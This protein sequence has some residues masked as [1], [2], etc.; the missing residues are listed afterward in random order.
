[1]EWFGFSEQ[2]DWTVFHE[3]EVLLAIDESADS[4]DTS[5]F[6]GTVIVP[7]AGPCS[8]RADF[9]IGIDDGGGRIRAAIRWWVTLHV[10]TAGGPAWQTAYGIRVGPGRRPP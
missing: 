7:A 9:R 4:G 10:T 5:L 1:M 3:E 8:D 2:Q 6:A